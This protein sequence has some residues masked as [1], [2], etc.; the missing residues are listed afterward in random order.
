MAELELTVEELETMEIRAVRSIEI[1]DI[2][3]EMLTAEK[4]QDPE[5]MAAAIARLE[6]LEA[7]TGTGQVRYTCDPYLAR[8]PG[9]SVSSTNSW[10]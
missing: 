9:A 7:A 4:N 2:C 3:L 6:H 8:S 5:R 10:K 1:S